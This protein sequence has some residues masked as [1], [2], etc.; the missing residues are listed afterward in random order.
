MTLHPF[1]SRVVINVKY[2]GIISILCDFLF[3][4]GDMLFLY[5]QLTHADGDRP[6]TCGSVSVGAS[7]TKDVV[8]EDEVDQLLY[9]EDGKIYRKKDEQL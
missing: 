6:G 4:H 8:V 1:N 3:R 2:H 5:S 7:S 9:K